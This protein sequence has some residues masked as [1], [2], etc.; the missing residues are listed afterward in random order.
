MF[1]YVKSARWSPETR[2]VG[3]SGSRNTAFRSE[4]VV[5][6][7]ARTGYQLSAAGR[8]GGRTRELR[9]QRTARSDGR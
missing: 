5:T 1:P 9:A 2:V 4:H 3:T 8:S 6:H 7:G